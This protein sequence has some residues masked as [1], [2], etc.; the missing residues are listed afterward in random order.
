MAHLKNQITTYF[1]LGTNLVKLDTCGQSHKHFTSVNYDSK[2]VPDWKLPHI[3]T[4]DS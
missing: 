4:L 2:V 1:L 3:V